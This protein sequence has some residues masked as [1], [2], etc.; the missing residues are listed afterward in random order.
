MT[1]SELATTPTVPPRDR[2]ASIHV[3][4]LQRTLRA[5]RPYICVD[6]D[7][8][9]PATES[10]DCVRVEVTAGELTVTALNGFAVAH[11]KAPTTG[12]DIGPLWFRH[13]QVD[14]LLR[15]LA[16]RPEGDDVQV[17]IRCP[18]GPGR[19][20]V[21]W[22]GSLIGDLTGGFVSRDWPRRKI[23]AGMAATAGKRQEERANQVD[24]LRIDL[25]FLAPLYRVLSGDGLVPAVPIVVTS[26]GPHLPVRV[27]FEDWFVLIVM[28]V[29]P[30]SGAPDTGVVFRPQ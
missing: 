23:N 28:P 7:Q 6:P 5:V 1:S 29:F 11:A 17:S 19:L 9:R 4:D 30:I 8:H 21:E 2:T 10:L 15:Q 18:Y 22:N 3:R 24:P 16:W 20:L 26:A 14:E 25:R 13:P 27:E 12:D